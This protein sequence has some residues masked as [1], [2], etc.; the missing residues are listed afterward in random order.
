M[1]IKEITYF[2]YLWENSLKNKKINS[3][4][5]NI[6]QLYSMFLREILWDIN[7]SEIIKKK[8]NEEHKIQIYNKMIE[9]KPKLDLLENILETQDF[10]IFINSNEKGKCNI[11]Q[12]SSSLSYLTGYQKHELINKPMEFL[13]PSIFIDGFGK[14]LEEY[15]KNYNSQ[16]NIDKEFYN[17]G[18]KKLNVLLIKSKIGYLIPFNAEYSIYDDNDFSNSYFIKIQLESIDSKSTYAYYILTKSDFSIEGISSSSIHLGLTIDLLKKYIIKINLLIRTSQDNSL[19]LFQKY[20]DYIENMKKVIWV[21][22]DI[23]YP[24]NEKLNNKDAPI[25][26]LIKASKKQKYNLQIFE[27]IYDQ[28]E[29]LGFLFKFIEISQKKKDKKEIL[30]EDYIPPFKNE[31]IFDMLKL[32]YIR[33]VLVKRN[34]D[35]ETLGIKKII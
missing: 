31:I 1:G 13:M 27:M 2:S 3:E 33:T 7:K 20:K 25:Q 30:A 24:K 4:N 21:F 17:G 15:I 18:D 22:P 11:N 10:T 6:V 34:Q 29:V 5:E 32:N 16:K 9:D 26:D 19:N 28:Q 35:L 14:N 8:I 12:V 23:I